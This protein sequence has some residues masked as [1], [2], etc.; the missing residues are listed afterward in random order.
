MPFHFPS[1]QSKLKSHTK[2]YQLYRI[3]IESVLGFLITFAGV[4]INRTFAHLKFKQKE[5]YIAIHNYASSSNMIFLQLLTHYKRHP[6]IQIIIRPN[7]L[8]RKSL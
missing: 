2:S 5:K 1:S 6:L 8:N 3:A 4:R 7:Y